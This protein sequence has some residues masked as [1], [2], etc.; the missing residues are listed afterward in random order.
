MFSFNTFDSLFD[1]IQNNDNIIHL[2][3]SEIAQGIVFP[4]DTLN[5]KNAKLLGPRFYEG[6]GIFV[7]SKE[8]KDGLCF[9]D[10]ELRLIKPYYTTSQIGRFYTIPY[11]DY[12]AIYTDSSYKNIH[13]LDNCPNI[14]NHL[15]KFLPIFTSDN[16]PYGLHRARKE[17]FFTGEKVIAIRK[18]VGKPIFAY[19]DFECY[20]SQ[21]FNMIQTKRV[22]QKYLT[23]L[24]NSKLIEFWLK[25]KGKM[26][27]DN[28]QLDKEPLQNVPIA[29]PSIDV[30]LLIAKLVIV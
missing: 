4:Q 16:R 10:Q 9:T 21:T 11:N 15:D 13:S 14:K 17:C 22:N 6:Q 20:L 12:W 23:G 18:C 24:L 7:L 25:N 27:G 19:C 29:A 28:F 8:E 26:Q 3:D 30:Q 5:K 1:L 2:T